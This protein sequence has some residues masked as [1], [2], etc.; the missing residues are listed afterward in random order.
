MGGTPMGTSRR[1]LLKAAAAAPI[2]ALPAT[3]AFGQ[4][5]DYPNKP[6][7]SIAMFAP[8]TGADV[9]VRFYSNKL[10]EATGK[11]V[12]VENKVGMGGN[13][14]T[15][16][17]AHAKPDGYT[18]YIAPSSSVLASA[19]SLFKKLPYDPL[20][21]FAHI[22]AVLK[23]AFIMVVPSTSP[24]TTVEQLTEH[25]RKK[26]DKAAYGSST[27][28]GHIA[29]ELYKTQFGLK[30]LEVPYK[31]GL[32]AINDL[33]AGQIDFFYTDSGTVREQINPGG[34]LRA[35]V[36]ASA[37]P[38]QAL[39]FIP[40]AKQAGLTMDLVGYWGIHVPVQT[41]QPIIDKLKAW[42]DPIV[43]S[44]DARKFLANVG[45]DPWIGDGKMVGDMLE[46]ETRN[47][48]KYVKLANIEPQ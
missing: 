20:K 14:A 24:I 42:F 36:T 39:P 5:A 6:I 45:Y 19:P 13:I 16:Y 44:E 46:R 4:Y 29:S 11:A 7:T 47:W 10:Q 40:G 43:R 48:A 3:R 17:V 34:R 9:V 2:L 21:D 38:I 22:T 41:P 35:L 31:S 28:T 26:G 30:A 23:V 37:D 15:D 1:S 25:L 33:Y 18:I 12:V 27:H 32:D 8:G